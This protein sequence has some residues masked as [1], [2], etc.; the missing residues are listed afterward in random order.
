VS[1]PL[2]QPYRRPP[3]LYRLAR[4]FRRVSLVVFVLIILFL[5]SAIYSA[6]EVVRSGPST[7][8]FGA[9]FA[10]NDTVA[11]S[12]ILNF[13]NPGFYPISGFAVHIRVLNQSQVYLGEGSAGPVTLAS[14]SNQPITITFYLPVGSSGPG[15]S[16][17]TQDQTLNVSVWGNATYAY[18]F[19]ISIAVETN[20]SWGAP[21]ADLAIS[22]GT[23]VPG[24]GG[25]VVPVT[26]QFQNHAKFAD[27]GE[28][29]F[30]IVPTGG[31]SC[32]SGSFDLDVGPGQQFGQTTNVP[33]SMGC[34]PSG[35][36]LEAEYVG[37]G[38]TIPLPPE[39]IP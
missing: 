30:A 38:V 15:A 37:N 3:G 27:S 34:S 18:L 11:V 17:L 26:V 29:T 1:N 21:F 31:P 20:K 6:V 33:I 23:P 25:A 12:G 10:A 36:Q 7:G 35:A 9:T 32:G 13:S 14:G 4:A 19:P 28:L 5:A 16:L 8:G 2:G 39:R 22:V 24:M